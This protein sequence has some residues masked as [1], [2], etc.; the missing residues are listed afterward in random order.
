[1]IEEQGA[2]PVTRFELHGTGAIVTAPKRPIQ[3][4]MRAS[5]WRRVLIALSVGAASNLVCID[6]RAAQY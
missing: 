4:I 3:A 2:S 5:G 6:R 1:M